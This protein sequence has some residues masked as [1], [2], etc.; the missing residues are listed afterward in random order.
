MLCQGNPVELLD[1][2]R[3]NGYGEC[4]AC[5]EEITKRAQAAKDKKALYG[6]D[7]DL[8]KY[9]QQTPPREHITSLSALSTGV[10]ERALHCGRGRL[11]EGAFRLVLHARPVR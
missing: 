10:Q 2:I 5:A 8:E 1:D 9:Q 6:N 11:D 3:K 7:I 4:M